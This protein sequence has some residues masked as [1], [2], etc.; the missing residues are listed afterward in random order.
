MH[1]ELLNVYL[2][3]LRD[4]LI[5]LN[6]QLMRLRGQEPDE[7]M[8]NT[9]FRVAHTIKGNSAAMEFMRIEKVMHSME[10]L[11]QELR[12]GTRTL[13]EAML[14]VFFDCH[15]F[16]ED[17]IDVVARDQSDGQLSIEAITKKLDLIKESAGQPEQSALVSDEENE[18][19]L[20]MQ[21]IT[22][23]MGLGY[24]VYEMRI[25]LIK[26]CP[27]KT[28]RIWMVF[29]E[30]E[31]HAT[32]VDSHPSRPSDE[33][34]RNPDFQFAQNHIDLI[35]LSEKEAQELTDAVLE[36][37]DIARVEIRKLHEP[38]EIRQRLDA[39]WR[40]EQSLFLL[41][42]MG[43][44]ILQEEYS[45]AQIY[46]LIEHIEVLGKIDALGLG[47]VQDELT[48]TAV[49]A[50]QE[51]LDSGGR[52]SDE[53]LEI[54]VR[55]FKELYQAIKNPHDV[56]RDEFS[57]NLGNYLRS[58]RDSSSGEE[59]KMGEIMVQRGLLREEDVQEILYKQKTQHPDLKFGQVAAMEHGVPPHEVMQILK[60]QREAE[61]KKAAVP[62]AKAESGFVRVPVGKVDG[63]MDMLGEL[64][65]LNAQLEDAA[66]KSS[67]DGGM[68]NILSRTAKLIK[69]IQSLSMTLRMVEIRPT[70]HRLTRIARDTAAELNKR[71]SVNLEGE[72]TEIDRS[73]AERLFDPLMHLVRNAVS[74]GIEEEQERAAAGKKSEGQVIVRCYSKRGNV[75]IEVEDDGRGMD[76]R[77]ILA[78]AKNLGMA[79]ENREYTEDEIT[80][81]IFRP[82]FSTQEQINSISGRGVGMNVV[83][84]EIRRT[85]GRV[86]II[87]RPGHG[88]TFVL[89]IPMNLAV[90]NGTVIQI[91][92]T[93]YI[94]PTL[95]IKEFY[96]AEEKDW[97]VVRG[98]LSAVR[99]RNSI[100]PIL[101]SEALFS[102]GT[103]DQGKPRK[104]LV[105]LELDQ[106]LLAFPVDRIVARQEIVSKPLI[107]ELSCVG[108]ASGASILGDGSVSL[109]LDV[110][111]MFDLAAKKNK[112]SQ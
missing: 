101:K 41:K 49:Q 14:D 4:S 90:L 60:E 74:H 95:F 42:Q 100:V 99:L 91:E 67:M 79:E 27:M 63:L 39:G 110:E 8:I 21:V 44:I 64:L 43:I 13:T 6:D 50:W 89:R 16:L 24:N 57:R 65:I 34:F 59:S 70:L 82:G 69:S 29:E 26:D 97:V 33:E 75:Y 47:P 76:L 77:K 58:L 105:V 61:E 92:E 56:N 46:E 22:A 68:V 93:R 62:S 45:A 32:L 111:Y 20:M 17:C 81:F 52:L 18:I 112:I 11:L 40:A 3:D 2:E 19:E 72:S 5:L 37:S 96:V 108:F 106:R 1:D 98:R 15:D 73:A 12:N 7:S 88:C 35:L 28:V 25:R 51:A 84:E 53:G 94:I 23:N 109:I 71:V 80:R 107:S 83:E 36:L 48:A 85:G 30:L 54:M 86:D 9:I 66:G 78:K 10:D 103:A 38:D 31:Q 87:N 102:T 104:E 55:I